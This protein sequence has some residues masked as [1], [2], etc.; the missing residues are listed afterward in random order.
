MKEEYFLMLK[1]LSDSLKQ[2]IESEKR[3]IMLLNNKP[4]SNNYMNL[5]SLKPSTINPQSIREMAI[6]DNII[7]ADSKI[8]SLF[9]AQW[10]LMTTL[11][12]YMAITQIIMNQLLFDKEKK[13]LFS[14]RS[15][16][17]KERVKELSQQI[18]ILR[19]EIES[20]K[21]TVDRLK[22]G[23]EQKKKWMSDNQ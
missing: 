23:M 11:S 20:M 1:D 4:S 18:E 8:D 14:L 6:I 10:Y 2:Q 12:Q 7:F 19:K 5:Y 3:L 16:S 9:S 17:D 15:K 13:S 21:P 22:E